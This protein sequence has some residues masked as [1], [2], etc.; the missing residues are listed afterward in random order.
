[1]FIGISVTWNLYGQ[2]GPEM[3]LP[4]ETEKITKKSY[5]RFEVFRADTFKY[6][7][8]RIADRA[9]PFLN[10]FFRSIRYNLFILLTSAIAGRA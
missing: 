2:A 9:G 8:L 3:S 5:I 4:E 10:V 7:F 6:P 1:L